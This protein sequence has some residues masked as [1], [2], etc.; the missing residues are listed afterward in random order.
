[1]RPF[2][3]INAKTTSEA[4]IALS[5]AKSKLIAGGTDLLGT[6][7][8][9]IL[10]V[11]PER[12]VNLKTTDGLE[13]I[14]ERNGGLKIG[15]L[16]KLSS[17]AESPVVI[18]K[19][20]ALSQ[21]AGHV[22][23]PHIRDMATIG[24]NL[25]QLPR[26]WYFRKAGN[27]FHCVRK[28]GDECYA[29][30]GDN[31]FH[32]MFG[33]KQSK[34]PPCASECPAGTDIPGYLEAIR[35]DDWDQAAE[36]FMAVHPF[37]MITGRVC[38]HFCQS[39]C[40]RHQTDEGVLTGGVE[41]ALGDYILKNSAKF[42]AP[43]QKEN[44]K[45]VAVVGSGPAGL[46]AAYFLRRAGN[47][48]TVFDRMTDAG[49]MLM[50]AIPAYR[51]PKD[52]VKKLIS[53]LKSMGIEFKLGADFAD[54]L[55]PEK[56]EKAFDGVVYATGAWKRPV[57]GISGEEL[58]IFGLDFLVEVRQW[59]G[60]HVGEEVLVVG[61]G[62]VAMD[63]AIT[64]KR[65]GAKK[66]TLACIEPRDRMPASSEEIERAEAEG[67]VIMP[68]WGPSGV[69]EENGIVSG[70]ELKR[71]TSV[72]DESG[73]FDPQ[74]DDSEKLV[75]KAQN[76]LLAIG[77]RVEL[78]FLSEKY[79]I[80]LNKRGLIDVDMDSQMTSRKGVFA[81][82]DA[83]TGPATVVQAVSNGK[84]AADGLNAYLKI[85]LQEPSTCNSCRNITSDLNGL[86]NKTALKLKELEPEK[87]CMEL[88]DAQ[89]P[90]KKDAIGEACRC[91][92]CGCYAVSPSDVAP[93][94]VALNAEIITNNRTISADEFFDAGTLSSTV[95]EHDE[96]ITEIVI[97]PL[98]DGARSIF[99]KMA[100]RKSIDFP[101]INFAIVT[102][103]NPRI[104]MGAVAPIPKRAKYAEDILRGK[105]KINEKVA[106]A[107]GEAAI[108]DAAP[109]EATKYKTQITK[110]LIKRAL[111]E[112]ES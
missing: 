60:G 73:V 34:R 48:V 28:G 45:S 64:A 19:F 31:R 71:C 13:Y 29:I 54:H 86:Q 49:G 36:I 16:T 23:T 14:K 83:T 68:S 8:D 95:L 53:A 46:T 21:A 32:S 110:T 63:V 43:P 58:T 26:C 69:K 55:P 70:M 94:L 78:S 42:Y 39:A 5:D 76:I 66:V 33:G 27:R 22:A 62:N 65:L 75:V 85:E 108:E 92:N 6:L 80:Q 88:E 10:P 17:I 2:K 4:S 12:I 44:G 51:L 109:F 102:G 9:D 25:A 107:V 74:Y 93:A 105:K 57:V 91:L 35:N 20:K 111:L 50:Y 97:P 56:L 104:C 67:I 79:H 90:T 81:A 38:A 96:V 59:M 24:G 47:K 89:T 98:P 106:T 30:L 100:T 40:N 99:K 3:H 11:Y 7:K 101:I 61:G 41:R 103:E 18:E 77:Q 72:F 37:P 87:R 82:G 84:K 15:A 52:I 1:M 112:L